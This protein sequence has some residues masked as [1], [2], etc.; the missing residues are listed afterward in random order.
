MSI[1]N[2]IKRMKEKFSLKIK[3]KMAEKRHNKKLQKEFMSY[4]KK[5]ENETEVHGRKVSILK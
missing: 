4:K 2:R 3:V 1:Q 5:E